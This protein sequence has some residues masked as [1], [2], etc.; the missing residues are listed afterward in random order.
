MRVAHERRRLPDCAAVFAIV[1]QCRQRCRIAGI[2]RRLSGRE[3]ADQRSVGRSN[4]C[5]SA[6]R[7]VAAP[8]VNENWRVALFD[9]VVRIEDRRVNDRPEPLTRGVRGI[10]RNE[11]VDENLIPLQ[12]LIDAVWNPQKTPSRFRRE[13]KRGGPTRRRGH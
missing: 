12:H 7:A 4:D 1:A 11:R 5:S 2:Q 6:R 3:Q 9:A 8:C 10:R 13:R